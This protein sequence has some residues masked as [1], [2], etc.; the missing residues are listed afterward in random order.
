MWSA[1]RRSNQLFIC[2]GSQA[3]GKAL[4]KDRLSKWIV[5]AITLAYSTLGGAPPQGLRTH[6]N[7]GVAAS[8]ALLQGVS[9][10]DICA[11]ASWTT[12]VRF[13]SLD[14][15]EATVAHSVLNAAR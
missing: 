14:M 4:S 13:Y 6:S 9:V 15:T 2:Y 12:F 7:R 3:E 8:W 10:E 5:E 1:P 11:T